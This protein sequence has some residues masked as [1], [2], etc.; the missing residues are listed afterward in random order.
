MRVRVVSY[1]LLIL[2]FLILGK[3][4]ARAERYA[5]DADT[6]KVRDRMVQPETWGRVYQ[7]ITDDPQVP[8]REEV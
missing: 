1:I 8:D 4:E 5:A 2:S 7:W 6:C 3:E